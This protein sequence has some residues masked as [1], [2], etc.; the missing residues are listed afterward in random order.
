MAIRFSENTNAGTI[1][2]LNAEELEKVLRTLFA[3]VLAESEARAK[4]NAGKALLT[5]DD[6]CK[7]F[8]VNKSTLWRWNRDG[9]LCTVKV[10]SKAFYRKSD[11]DK[12]KEGRV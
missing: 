4:E 8:D 2:M 9:Y 1:V 11:V 5:V 10:G 3:D 6:V 12:L 7:E